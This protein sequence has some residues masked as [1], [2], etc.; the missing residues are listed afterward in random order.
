MRSHD[1]NRLLDEPGVRDGGCTGNSFC[2]SADVTNRRGAWG[3][4]QPTGAKRHCNACVL[5]S[6]FSASTS[7]FAAIFWLPGR[8]LPPNSAAPV[9]QAARGYEAYSI[10]TPAQV[11]SGARSGVGGA[12]RVRTICMGWPQ[13]GQRNGARGLT[14]AVSAVGMIFNTHCNNAIS[15]GP[16]LAAGYWVASGYW[17]SAASFFDLSLRAACIGAAKTAT[18]NNTKSKASNSRAA[19]YS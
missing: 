7:N 15:H 10:N 19:P 17:L 2:S 12:I 1:L 5:L 14:R 11:L 8:A 18:R 6:T 3:A 13:L 16:R 9:F 4:R